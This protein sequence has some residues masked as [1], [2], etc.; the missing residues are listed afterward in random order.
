MGLPPACVFLLAASWRKYSEPRFAVVE[1]PLRPRTAAGDILV[2][3]IR[4]S[5]SAKAVL[6]RSRLRAV[7]FWGRGV[8]SRIRST[9]EMRFLRAWS[10][11]RLDAILQRQGEPK[12][13]RS[14]FSVQRRFQTLPPF[15]FAAM[16]DNILYHARKTPENGGAKLGHERP[17][18]PDFE[19]C[20]WCP[21]GCRSEP[22]LSKFNSQ[23]DIPALIVDRLDCSPQ[24]GL[25][26][27]N[28][29]AKFNGETLRLC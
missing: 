3:A 18:P 20:G 13:K 15:G 1:P 8:V 23:W 16:N 17:S 6:N 22:P 14:L 28:E 2:W 9:S 19:T 11:V 21:S 24:H 4:S 26:L 7:R 27:R 25:S 5:V 29:R 10:S 12:S